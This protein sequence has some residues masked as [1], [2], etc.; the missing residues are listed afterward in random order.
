MLRKEKKSHAS[1]RPNSPKKK[2]SL[3]R[4]KAACIKGGSPN[5]TL[6]LPFSTVVRPEPFSFLDLNSAPAP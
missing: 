3:Y 4:P 5:W 6:H 1:G 2:K